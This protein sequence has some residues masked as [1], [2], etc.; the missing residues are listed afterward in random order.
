MIR[1]VRPWKHNMGCWELKKVSKE[2][3]GIEKPRVRDLGSV[4]DRLQ[5]VTGSNAH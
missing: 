5:E 1:K 3:R 2:R 4:G